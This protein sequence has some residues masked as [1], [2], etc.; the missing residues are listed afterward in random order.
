M[1]VITIIMKILS[2]EKIEIKKLLLI[3]LMI[4]GVF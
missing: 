1:I 4:A 2:K 3:D